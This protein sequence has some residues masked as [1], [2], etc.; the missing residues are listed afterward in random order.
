MEFNKI[1]TLGLSLLLGST[2]SLSAQKEDQNIYN[3]ER[4]KADNP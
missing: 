4:L 1:Y 2:L 3:M